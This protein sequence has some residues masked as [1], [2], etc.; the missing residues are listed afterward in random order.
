MR[1]AGYK[2]PIWLHGTIE[3]M[4]ELYRQRG[5]E[6]GDLPLVKEAVD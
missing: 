5:V 4:C 1:V 2:Q 6:L 3:A